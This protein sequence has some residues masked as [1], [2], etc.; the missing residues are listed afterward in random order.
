MSIRCASRKSVQNIKISSDNLILLGIFIPAL[1]FEMPSSLISALIALLF[2]CLITELFSKSRMARLGVHTLTD[3][4]APKLLSMLC[5]ESSA[6]AIAKYSSSAKTKVYCAPTALQ[7]TA[8]TLGGF[9]PKLVVTGRLCVAAKEFPDETRMILRHELAHLDNHDMWLWQFLISTLLG[10]VLVPIWVLLSDS[11][12]AA[13]VTAVF[14]PQVILISLYLLLLCFRRREFLADAIA[15]NHTEDRIGYLRLLEK[16]RFHRKSWF[17]PSPADRI[18]AIQSD[19]PVLRTNMAMLLVIVV[20][21]SGVVADVKV[22]R[23]G[24]EP[25][26]SEFISLIIAL[27]VAAVVFL[28]AF[29]VE[30]RKG[31]R[32]KIPLTCADSD[33][34]PLPRAGFLSPLAEVFG[35]GSTR[36]DAV[37]ASALLISL[38]VSDIAMGIVY[39]A[40]SNQPHE[41]GRPDVNSLI[42][43]CIV[44]PCLLLLLLRY[45]RDL[46][47]AGT[48]MAVTAAISLSL[49]PKAAIDISKISSFWSWGILFG[50]IFL[51]AVVARFRN[52][53]I[54][55][56]AGYLCLLI[57]VEFPPFDPWRVLQSIL[58]AGTF[59]LIIM[60]T[61]VRRRVADKAVAA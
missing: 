50:I 59:V 19:N 20:T 21:L 5:E 28:A 33:M 14:K 3:T 6:M 49:Y 11:E 32:R 42:W 16:G 40:L 58:F 57:A 41:F 18:A 7:A 51:G 31:P 1:L 12:E 48:I 54:G 36:F 45:M 39:R 17:H 24:Q 10:I 8:F 43:N 61:K 47:E 23:N 30:V 22:S 25:D 55:L 2:V 15:V 37:R 27:L 38:A 4:Q 44:W 60:V 52:T 35:V 56:S 46:F 13:V 34:K 29:A 9:R 26:S 53:F